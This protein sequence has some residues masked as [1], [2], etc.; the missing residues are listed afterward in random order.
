MR[1]L[2]IGRDM[3]CDIV[4]HSD[5]VSSLHAEITLLNSGDILLEDK[6]SHNG[7]Y[8]MNQ[9][10]APGKPVNIKR[11]MPSDLPM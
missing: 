6:N 8:V 9:P 11:G 10:I 3:S 7:T 2:K 4:L 1:L 5:K